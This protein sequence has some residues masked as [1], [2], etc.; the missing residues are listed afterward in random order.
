MYPIILAI[1]YTVI[2]YQ[3]HISVLFIFKM[4]NLEVGD[5]Y[6]KITSN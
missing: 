3:N 1:C 4:K 2:S 5:H 6:G